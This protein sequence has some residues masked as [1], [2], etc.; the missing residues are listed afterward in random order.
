M[1]QKIIYTDV[2]GKAFY[3]TGN[4][5]GRR[6]YEIW[7]NYFQSNRQFSCFSKA[8]SN[9]DVIQTSSVVE[10]SVPGII[11]QQNLLA[12]REQPWVGMA[13]NGEKAAREVNM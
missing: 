13:G 8:A 5:F 4:S 6:K 1:K 12:S 10:K 3:A 7:T 2:S 11:L 9:E